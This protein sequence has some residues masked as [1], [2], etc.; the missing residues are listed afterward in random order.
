MIAPF[1]ALTAPLALSLPFQELAGP[2]PPQPA[3]PGVPPAPAAVSFTWG[4][5]DADGV[6]DALTIDAAGGVS[7]MRSLGDGTLEDVTVAA[8]LDQ[9]TK[10]RFALWHDYDQDEA[11]DLFFGTSEGSAYLMQNQGG[12]FVDVTAASGIHALGGHRSAHWI[13]Y[14]SDGRLDLH[15]VSAG[16]NTL[17]RAIEGGS[18]EAIE[19]PG[20][21]ERPAGAISTPVA[22]SSAAAAPVAAAD[23]PRKADGDD[24]SAVVVGG[25]TVIVG[26][27]GIA[28]DP[29]NVL[30]C[31]T[32]LADLGGGGCLAASSAATLGM[33][34]PLSDKL[35]VA[36][37]TGNVGVGTA[38]P[39]SRLHVTGG[40]DAGLASNGYLQLGDTSA[41]NIVL[42]DNE[43]MARTNGSP[44]TL[45]VNADGGDV[46]FA[47][48]GAAGNVGVGVTTPS[49]RL[50]VD[51]GVDA[52]LIG[53]GYLQIG[54][55]SSSNIVFDQEEF[56][57][58]NNGA[59]STLSVNY[60]GGNV[61]MA[62]SGATG[63]LGI[64]TQSPA[65]R[66]H[67]A[68]G[69]DAGLTSNGHLQLGSTSGENL[70]LD[71]NE[72][73]ARSGGAAQTL[74]LNFDGGDVILGPTSVSGDVGIGTSTP[75][76]KLTVETVDGYG[77]VHRGSADGVE[78]ATYVSSSGAWVGS[79]T[80]HPLNFFTNGGG[81]AASLQTNGHF[82]V[83]VLEIEG[84]ADLVEGFDSTEELHPGTV[85]VIDPANPGGLVASAEAYD[86]KVAGI[87]SGAN[88]VQPGIELGQKGELDGDVKV[89]MT[90]RVWV[91]ASVEN[92]AIQPGDRLTTAALAGHAMRATDA[93][94]WDGAVIGKAMSVL[95][96][97]TGLVLVLVNLQ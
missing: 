91:Q 66:L 73:M 26:D 36:E 68:G 46:I 94:R 37:A 16:A 38:A 5:F 34:Y 20:L 43:I 67:I 61:T 19:L 41:G 72:V 7:L 42:D 22:G 92:G 93:A 83:Q 95:E 62:G 35:F 85:V 96:E 21:P 10:A 18:F 58:R 71:E 39:A 69:N 97:G 23:R 75:T 70:V 30:A 63:N 81:A 52:G 82:R 40:A 4:D 77:I 45:Y 29:E 53:N 49:A 86:R 12:F 79:R 47:G 3:D 51:Q 78:V 57:A 15:L 1:L 87:V 25:P 11:I 13:D 6:E 56:Q 27:S 32:S 65:S 24:R 33:L 74:Y 31:A 8:G 60:E 89:A 64:G 84:G 44:E 48:F 50:H 88:G 2:R 54:D 9:V 80:D 90:G 76:D 59:A 14:N 28:N 17:Y 55:P